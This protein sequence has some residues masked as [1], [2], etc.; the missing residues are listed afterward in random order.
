MDTAVNEHHL[1]VSALPGAIDPSSRIT[2]G[3]RLEE[4]TPGEPASFTVQIRDKERRKQSDGGQDERWPN[5][6]RL[7]TAKPRAEGTSGTKQY[8][9]AE[10]ME[11]NRVREAADTKFIIIF[12]PWN[13]PHRVDM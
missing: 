4:V 6:P 1:Q 11:R 12:S 5:A 7:G 13:C 10:W 9:L 3:R 8:G 2:W